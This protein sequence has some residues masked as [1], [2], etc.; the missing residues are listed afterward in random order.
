MGLFDKWVR[1]EV[2]GHAV[3]GLNTWFNGAAIFVDG[4]EV[5]RAQGLLALDEA[6]P[7]VEVWVK[8]P[9]GEMHIELH[10]LSVL[11]TQLELRV[12]G[13]HVAGDRLVKEDHA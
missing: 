12:N 4:V 6:Q 1:A 2:D 8:G 13:R 11:F 10:I 3:A 7:F 5:A 9:Q